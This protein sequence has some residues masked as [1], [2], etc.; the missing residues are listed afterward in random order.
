MIRELKA[1]RD[2]PRMAVIGSRQQMCVH[3]EVRL[4]SVAQNTA[5]GGS[6]PSSHPPPTS[7]RGTRFINPPSPSL[8]DA[9]S[10][11]RLTTKTN[12]CTLYIRHTRVYMPRTRLSVSYYVVERMNE[13]HVETR[14]RPWDAACKAKTDSRSCGH[15]NEVEHF[16]RAEPDFGKQEPAGT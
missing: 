8:V 7:P 3:K 5:G 9:V 16:S 11:A 15:H 2:R 10:G 13:R 12:V 14:E 6:P 1:T 4:L